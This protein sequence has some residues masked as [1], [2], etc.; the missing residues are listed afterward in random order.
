[1]LC[2][3]IWLCTR[4]PCPETIFIKIICS[5]ERCCVFRHLRDD[6]GWACRER[7]SELFIIIFW[8]LSGN[9][10]LAGYEIDRMDRKK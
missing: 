8:W 1:M 2:Y 9:S 7:G 5:F 10:C 6:S 3:V 4:R